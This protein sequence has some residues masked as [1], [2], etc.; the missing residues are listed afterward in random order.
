MDVNATILIEDIVT[1]HCAWGYNWASL[2]LGEINTGTWPPR[3]GESKKIE[4]I[5]YARESHGTQM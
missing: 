1:G 2:F 4:T 3:L 5:K